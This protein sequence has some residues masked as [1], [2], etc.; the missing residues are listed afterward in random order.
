MENQTSLGGLL[1]DEHVVEHIAPKLIVTIL[2]ALRKQLKGTDPLNA[3]EEIACPVPE[4]SIE[5]D[6]ILTDGGGF[7]DDVN[8]GYLP[9]YLVLAARREVIAWVHSAG[10]YE[11]VPVQ[12][13]RDAGKRLLDLF[14][15]DRQICGSSSQE[16]SIKSVCQ[17]VQDEEAC[18]FQ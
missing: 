7:W 14:W 9:E 13:C 15:V 3:V 4:I 18:K 8:G 12:E 6:Q 5:H 11:V 16:D 17:R 2:K 10:V 1:F